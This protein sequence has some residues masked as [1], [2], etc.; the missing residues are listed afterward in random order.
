MFPGPHAQV[1]YNEA[2]E[3][4][5]WDNPSDDQPEV[6]GRCGLDGHSDDDCGEDSGDD[7]DASS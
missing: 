4:I 2:G 7:E 5:G 3:P 1:Y 6:C